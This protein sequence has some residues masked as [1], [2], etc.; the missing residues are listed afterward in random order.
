MNALT[1]YL[2]LIPK[3]IKEA[4]HI[5]EGIVNKVKLEFNAMPEE[6][7]REIVKRRVICETCPFNSSNAVSNPSINYKTDR[8]D[9]H[10]IHCGCN[11]DFKT[12]ALEEQCG[13]ADYNEEHPDNPMQ[14]KWMKYKKPNNE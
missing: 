3:A 12:A 14:V 9:A 11:I 2:K 7:K 6:E 8:F 4:P 1:E 5:I 10:C 13:I